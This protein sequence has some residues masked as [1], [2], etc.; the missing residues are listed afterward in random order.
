[1][2]IDWEALSSEDV[3]AGGATPAP[4]SHDISGAADPTDTWNFNG[5]GVLVGFAVNAAENTAIKVMRAHVV[6]NLHSQVVTV[7]DPMHVSLSEIPIAQ[8]V[9]YSRGG[10]YHRIE[11]RLGR[12][13]I[14]KIGASGGN[15]TFGGIDLSDGYREKLEAYHRDNVPVFLDLKHKGGDYTRFY[16]TI[17]KMSQDNP[18]GNQFAK[19]GISLSVSYIIEFTSTGTWTKKISLGGDI[20]DEP[21]YVF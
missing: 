8:S 19:F 5:Y 10:Q 6:N 14:R 11:D 4:V 7:R 20:A 3:Q 9:T 15:V 2:P 1:M 17:T 18:V 13:E 21:K 12:A 16:G